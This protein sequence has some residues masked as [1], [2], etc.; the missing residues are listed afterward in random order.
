MK[1]SPAPK[2]PSKLPE[3]ADHPGYAAAREQ[4]DRIKPQ[5]AQILSKSER[6]VI[7]RNRLS[8]AAR[9]HLSRMRVLPMQTDAVF[10]EICMKVVSAGEIAPALMAR[11]RYQVPKIKFSDSNDAELVD[12]IQEVEAAKEILKRALVL[13]EKEVSRQK[14]IAISEVLSNAALRSEREKIGRAVGSALAALVMA[15]KEEHELVSALRLQDESLPNLLWPRPFPFETLADPRL[16]EWLALSGRDQ[17]ID[18]RALLAAAPPGD[19]TKT[20]VAIGR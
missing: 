19:T 14:R 16:D 20:Q 2:A 5:L 8:E 15:L 6:H 11:L 9:N 17:A 7:L 13:A 18:A 3:L 1:H 10:D 12:E 4:L